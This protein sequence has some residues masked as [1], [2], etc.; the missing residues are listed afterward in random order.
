MQPV[1]RQGVTEDDVGN[2]LPFDQ[3]VGFTDGVRLGVELLPVHHQART[4]VEAGE[5]FVSHAEHAAGARSGVVQRAH[6]AG[7]GQG[8]VVFN[9]DQVDH[10]PNGVTRRE[11]FAR[12]F[13][14]Q[15]GKFADQLLK[16]CAHLLV[17]D[18]VRVQV[19]VGKLFGDDVEQPR[20]GEL[21][22]LSVKL[23]AF[24]NVAHRGRKRLHV[25]AQVFANMVLVA[26]QLFKIKRGGVVEQLTR[27]AQQERL[28]VEPGLLANVLFGEHRRFG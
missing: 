27:F 15:L 19:N 24:K 1:G 20:L 7:F 4:G 26:H 18:D 25:G 3:H 14:G 17:A 8:G 11:V 21:V 6:Y 5:V 2:I 12:G 22:D 13:V 9:K 10:E 16:H 28:G 23:K